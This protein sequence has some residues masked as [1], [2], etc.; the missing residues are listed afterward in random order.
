MIKEFGMTKRT[1]II[2]GSPRP[3]GNT[4]RLVEEMKKTLQ[5]D[6][7]E[8]S[9]YRSKIAPCVDC[10]GC[11][12]T[13]RCVVRDDM[14]IIYADDFDNVVVASPVYFGTMPGPMLSL[15]SRFQP[16]HAAMFFLDIDR[17]IS[18]KK[19]GL[20]MTA[21]SRKN[22]ASA[23]HHVRCL[24]NMVNARGYQGYEVI[25]NNTDEVPADQDEAALA[26]ARRLGE[27]LNED[28]PEDADLR[29][30]WDIKR[31]RA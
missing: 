16:Q 20:I 23:L 26:A 14:D 17:N 6:V 9:A 15:L 22:E 7:V 31:G 3:H 2:N 27:Y 1:L 12:T 25:S 29:D 10:R 24:F 30:L 13:A 18:P 8:I 5:G 11:S 28:W 19:A 21:G 4:A